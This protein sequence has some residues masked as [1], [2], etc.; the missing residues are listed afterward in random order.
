MS[1]APAYPEGVRTAY[2]IGQLAEAAGVPTSTVRYYERRG[3]LTE[4]GRSA[5]NFRVYGPDAV[6]RLGF[7]RS[8]QESGFTLQDIGLLLALR[9]GETDPCGEVRDVIS[10]RLAAV[11]TQLKDLRHVQKV[12]RSALDW[13]ESSGGDGEC[14]LLD[15]LDR[16]GSQRPPPKGREK[17]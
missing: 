2:T 14:V 7:I 13:C 8:A 17:R 16:Q 6:R 15:D 11:S 9:D 4:P 5:G 10:T 3:L 1:G 12:L